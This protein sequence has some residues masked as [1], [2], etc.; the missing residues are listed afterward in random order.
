MYANAMMIYI[1]CVHIPPRNIQIGVFNICVI[2]YVANICHIILFRH[3]L[4]MHHLLMV[5]NIINMS[6]IL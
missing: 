4:Y 6:Q 2:F 5:E 1:W 3:N